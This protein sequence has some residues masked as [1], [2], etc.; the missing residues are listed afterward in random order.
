MVPRSVTLSFDNGPTVGVTDIVLDELARRGL[1]AYFFVV[2]SALRNPGAR[3]LA[4]RAVAEGHRIGNHSATHRLALGELS[5]PSDVDAE[6]DDCEVLLDGL[7]CDP[8]LFRPFGN[9]GLLD[10]RLLGER[11][12]ER[13]TAGG[14]TT[15]LWNSVPHDWDDP[16]GWV[17]RALE[18]V[19]RLD[20]TL[21]VLH[22][23]PGAAVGRLAELLDKLSARDVQFTLAIPDD[24]LATCAG[25]PMP[26]LENLR[27]DASASGLP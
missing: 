16:V 11:A 25:E 23:T 1:H 19:A 9:G 6:I 26:A 8:P 15:V 18:D 3:A 14:Y 27:R 22:D 21:L 5:S 24:C 10:H 13:L 7:R 2:G 12:I 17:D 20:H 4:E